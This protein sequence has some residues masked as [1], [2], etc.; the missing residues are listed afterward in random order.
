MSKV[1]TCVRIRMS[2]PIDR[3]YPKT[4]N[5]L[6]ICDVLDMW[7]VKNN[8]FESHPTQ[9]LK[10]RLLICDRFLKTSRLVRTICHGNAWLMH[11]KGFKLYLHYTKKWVLVLVFWERIKKARKICIWKFF[12]IL[13]TREDG[14]YAGKRRKLEKEMCT[15]IH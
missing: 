14:I 15:I 11:L 6:N 12:H 10:K 3:S 5:P 1:T 4:G 13:Q 9:T 2:R 7:L 8:L